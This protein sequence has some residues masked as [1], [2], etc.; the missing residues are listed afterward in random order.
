M[1][2][3]RK[4]LFYGCLIVFGFSA[5]NLSASGKYGSSSMN[6]NTD[7]ELLTRCGQITVRISETPAVTSEEHTSLPA[8]SPV[9]VTAPRN[10]GIQVVGWNGD[11]FDVTVCKAADASSS[12]LLGAV[13]TETSGGNLS[14][15]G[16]SEEGW[17]AYVLIKAPSSAR[18]S[19]HSTNGPIGLQEVRGTFSADAKN[20][21]ISLRNNDASID[22]TTQNGPISLAG[23]SGQ[24]RLDA[25]NGPV[26][27]NLNGST[28]ENGSLDART[29]NGPVSLKLSRDFRSGVV[30]ESA[31]RGPVSCRCDGARETRTDD[32][33]R[34][35]FGSGSRPIVHLTT[36][37]GPVSIR[38]E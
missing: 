7:G 1:R 36:K 34:A 11:H 18:M 6:V 19:L 33:Y 17:T 20:G 15:T 26:S 2:T 16:P 5:M 8:G 27:L 12:S 37:N 3:S 35:E 38:N 25:K 24:V 13:R 29:Q 10:G 23:G 9:D 14:V 21:P 31:G 4:S 22:A 32:L 30:V 28:W